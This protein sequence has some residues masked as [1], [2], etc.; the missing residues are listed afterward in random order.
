[1]EEERGRRRCYLVEV[2][3]TIPSS[4]LICRQGNRYAATLFD[5]ILKARDSKP[6]FAASG[7]A[8]GE[9]DFRKTDLRC[10]WGESLSD[11]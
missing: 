6:C 3:E 9:G 4:D 1:M 10:M 11:G 2:A 5:T 8:L 7:C